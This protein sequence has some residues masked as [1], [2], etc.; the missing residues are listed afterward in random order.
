MVKRK[1]TATRHARRAFNLVEMII[2]SLL[3]GVIAIGVIPL[4]TR[5]I[6]NNIYGADASQLASFLRSGTERVQQVS[7]NDGVLLADNNAGDPLD[8]GGL[9]PKN[10]QTDPNDWIFSDNTTIRS[11]PVYYDSGARDSTTKADKVLG[12]ESWK[13][14]GVNPT[15]IFLW[16]QRREIREYSVADVFRGNI[17]VNTGGGS[18]TLTPLGNPKL[19]DTPL[20]LTGRPDIREIRMIVESTKGGIDSGAASTPTGIKQKSLV[21]IYRAF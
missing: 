17:S 2:T 7:A 21:K 11:V 9:N 10:T 4:F 18:A 12:D 1:I 15:G 6:S 14:D 16:R 19:F 5:A 20:E 8:P 3:V 13:P